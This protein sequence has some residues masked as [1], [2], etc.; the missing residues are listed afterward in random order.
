LIFSPTALVAKGATVA[1]DFGKLSLHDSGTVQP[2]NGWTVDSNAQG[3]WNTKPVRSNSPPLSTKRLSSWDTSEP[4]GNSAGKHES[5]STGWTHVQASSGWNSDPVKDDTRDGTSSSGHTDFQDPEEEVSR[6]IS[7]DNAR[8]KVE[9][10]LDTPVD[11]VKHLSP[12]ESKSADPASSGSKGKDA[13]DE[14]KEVEHL[15]RGYLVVKTRRRVTVDGGRSL[16]AIEKA[17]TESQDES[18]VY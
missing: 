3:G 12:S 8:V 10:G 1:S 2:S 4:N 11:S 9:T 7:Q 18:H 13:G 16:L 15:G 5:E 17:G 6:P 14:K